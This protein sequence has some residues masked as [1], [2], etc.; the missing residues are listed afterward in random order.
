MSH[1][2]IHGL[3]GKMGQNISKLLSSKSHNSSRL[4]GGSSLKEPLIHPH[5]LDEVE[6]VF[7]FSGA[8]G[9][10]VLLDFLSKYE[11]KK[12]KVLIGSTGLSQEDIKQWQHLAAEHGH[13]VLL[14]ANTSLGILVLKHMSQV[15][16][17]VLR[18]LGFDIELSETHHKDKK[19]A[20]SGTA[21]M[22]A[23]AIKA[24]DKELRLQ[25]ERRTETRSPSEIG[26]H[27]L[28]GGGVYGEHTIHFLGALE[29]ISLSHK[30]LD[31]TLFAEGALVLAR[32]LEKKQAGFYDLESLNLEELSLLSRDA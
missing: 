9:N 16:T 17:R 7:D 26:L 31:R 32:W 8:L 5:S 15:L 12:K 2:W 30:A 13:T 1:Y 28:R 19:D 27:A 4:V 20:P 29:T 24:E 11:L 21:L 22:L 10:K 3:S 14:A 25:M 6:L 23:E 18:P